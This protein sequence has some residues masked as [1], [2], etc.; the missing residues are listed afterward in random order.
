MELYIISEH[1]KEVYITGFGISVLPCHSEMIQSHNNS[2]SH[3]SGKL[4]VKQKII[5]LTSF[6]TG[7]D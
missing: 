6:A 5:C 7:N 2:Y 4:Y 3:F 1:N